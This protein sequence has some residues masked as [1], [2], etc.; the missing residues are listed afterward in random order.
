ME[1][2]GSTLIQRAPFPGACSSA[3]SSLRPVGEV[4]DLL[5]NRH[6]RPESLGDYYPLSCHAV[7]AGGFYLEAKYM[8]LSL[9]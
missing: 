5:S 6:I 8:N 7:W 4:I 1:D 2:I 3:A 9:S